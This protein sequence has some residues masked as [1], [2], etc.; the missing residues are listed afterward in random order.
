MRIQQRRGK[1]CFLNTTRGGKGSR[2]ERKGQSEKR[3]RAFVH[4][5]RGLLPTLVQQLQPLQNKYYH[6]RKAYVN[7]GDWK[8][9][10]EAVVGSYDK[11]A[12]PSGISDERLAWNDPSVKA[13]RRN[14]QLER[15]K[16][17]KNPKTWKAWDVARTFGHHMNRKQKEGPRGRRELEDLREVIRE[18]FFHSPKEEQ[19]RRVQAA[20]KIQRIARQRAHTLQS[21]QTQREKEHQR[22][23]VGVDQSL[24]GGAG[25]LF[26]ER[27]PAEDKW[28][29]FKQ[30]H[31]KGKRVASWQ[32]FSKYKKAQDRT[33]ALAEM[34]G[35]DKTRVRAQV[36]WQNM[37]QHLLKKLADQQ[38]LGTVEEGSL[39]NLHFAEDT[40]PP[41]LGE[42]TVPDVRTRRKEEALLSSRKS[43]RPSKAP[44]RLGYEEE[45]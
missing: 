9:N 11:F 39:R 26:A 17:Y 27:L 37:G 22:R 7:R 32:R 5:V 12:L 25:L 1:R 41:L 18:D 31:Q 10:P 6:L 34:V 15:D 44:T 14:L 23:V 21:L 24:S 36:H 38:A 43:G 16:Q 29:E 40:T 2:K 28:E 19:K 13:Y 42:D 8:K 4:S 20:L 45:F 33:A 35:Y 30:R 3:N